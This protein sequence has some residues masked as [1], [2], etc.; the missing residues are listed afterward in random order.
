MSIY[1]KVRTSILYVFLSSP[2]WLFLNLITP[3]AFHLEDAVIP[4][5]TTIDQSVVGC[6]MVAAR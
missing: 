3:V 5:G 1:T 4:S 6:Y 2:L